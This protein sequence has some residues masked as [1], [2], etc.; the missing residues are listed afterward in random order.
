[1]ARIVPHNKL[2]GRTVASA[3]RSACA[4]GFT[5]LHASR[6]VN[7]F[8]VCGRGG[9]AKL[10]SLIGCRP[11]EDLDRAATELLSCPGG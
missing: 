11:A 5:G 9:V 6:W 7:F 8:L 10:L 3:K 1:V 4:S 2:P